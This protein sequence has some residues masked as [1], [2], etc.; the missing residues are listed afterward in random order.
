[1][2]AE[3]KVAKFRRHVNGLAG[4]YYRLDKGLTVGRNADATSE[5]LDWHYSHARD[6]VAAEARAEEAPVCDYLDSHPKLAAK[7][8]ALERRY[9]GL[10]P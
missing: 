5:T 7:W 3:Q 1:M 8:N 4:V 10:A 9:H 6:M 2:D